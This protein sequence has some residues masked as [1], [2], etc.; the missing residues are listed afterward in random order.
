M[1]GSI[2]LKAYQERMSLRGL[3]RTF[4]IHRHTIS[5]WIRMHVQSL[6]NV[7]DT[8]LPAGADDVLEY[9]EA[10]SFVPQEGQ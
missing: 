6:P 5:R 4:G 1:R 8:L 10:W 3:A 9:D 2:I 7:A